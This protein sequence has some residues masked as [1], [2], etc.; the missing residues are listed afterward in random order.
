[1][2]ESLRFIPEVAASL[3][4]GSGISLVEIIGDQVEGLSSEEE[5]LEVPGN[6]RQR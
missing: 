4:E 2:K 1:M 3:M 6:Y 5:K